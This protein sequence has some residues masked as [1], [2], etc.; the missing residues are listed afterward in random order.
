MPIMA[1]TFSADAES[2]SVA[3]AE[4]AGALEDDE[5]VLSSNT[6]ASLSI[7]GTVVSADTGVDPIIVVS[8]DII[9]VSVATDARN[10]PTDV[11]V[12]RTVSFGIQSLNGSGTVSF[13]N[14]PPTVPSHCSV[15]LPINSDVISPSPHLRP[16]T[17]D[18]SP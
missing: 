7:V 18:N 16:F 14:G 6:V 13:V 5:D 4:E 1:A 15:K 2:V 17:A 12:P 3:G 8:V 9:P 11:A 10:V